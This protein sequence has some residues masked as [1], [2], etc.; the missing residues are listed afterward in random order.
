MTQF[1]VIK[2]H[3]HNKM[4]PLTHIWI[5]KLHFVSKMHNMH[6]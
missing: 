2:L 6:Y 5:N 3:I 4:V 1:V